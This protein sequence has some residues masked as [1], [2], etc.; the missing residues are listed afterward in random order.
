[1][2]IKISGTRFIHKS[3][4]NGFIAIH[5]VCTLMFSIILLGTGLS[6]WNIQKARRLLAER[7]KKINHQN[8]LE[9]EAR[10][11]Q[12]QLFNNMDIYRSDCSVIENS[13]SE[14]KEIICRNEEYDLEKKF[15]TITDR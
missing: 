1:M 5:L 15:I 10:K 2:F 13:S 9:D 6:F 12:I 3:S 14:V 11:F 4:A 7:T 8:I